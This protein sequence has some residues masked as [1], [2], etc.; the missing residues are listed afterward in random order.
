[1]P[2]IKGKPA[3]QPKLQCHQCRG[4]AVTVERGRNQRTI[5]GVLRD[6]ASVKCANRD[7]QNQWWSYHDEALARS[8]AAEDA[9]PGERPKPKP[10][11]H[12][13][14]VDRTEP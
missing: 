2:R 12:A 5:H 10:Q 4:T 9:A 3:R 8:R 6:V 1:M 11:A 7:C 14:D 13:G